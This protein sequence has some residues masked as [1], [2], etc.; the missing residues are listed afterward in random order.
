MQA[1]QER[2]CLPAHCPRDSTA[3]SSCCGPWTAARRRV[4]DLS[5]GGLEARLGWG[6]PWRQPRKCGGAE[7]PR[8]VARQALFRPPC[9]QHACR[10]AAVCALGLHTLQCLHL[11]GTCI[12]KCQIAFLSSRQKS[13]LCISFLGCCNKAPQTGWLKNKNW[14]T[15]L[16]VQ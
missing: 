7:L 3:W 2:L 13:P 8:R 11:K 5:A 15:S 16:V 10:R 12:H 14:G 9:C 4:G 1:S 6:G